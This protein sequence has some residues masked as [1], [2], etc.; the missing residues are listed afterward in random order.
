MAPAAIGIAP[1]IGCGLIDESGVIGVVEA[2]AVV[3]GLAEAVVVTTLVTRT[4]AV[5]VVRAVAAVAAPRIA[6]AVHG[7]AVVWVGVAAAAAVASFR[8]GRHEAPV[9]A[10]APAPVHAPSRGPVCRQQAEQGEQQAGHVIHLL[11][12]NTGRL[13][14][15]RG[16]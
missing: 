2:V 4:E 5:T 7:V 9:M 12:L 13:R 11:V 3:V 8:G 6:A 15:R 1:V 16:S 10:H 14:R